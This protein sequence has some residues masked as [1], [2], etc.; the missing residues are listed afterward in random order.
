MRAEI[1]NAL[2]TTR[3]T[4]DYPN[5]SNAIAA[6]DVR[7]S[8]PSLAKVFSRCFFTVVRPI[9]RIVAISGF[10]FPRATQKRISASRGVSP[11]TSSCAGVD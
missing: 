6:A 4:S 7:F 2:G 1:F 3:S 11:S 8:T 5:R 10:V 9:P